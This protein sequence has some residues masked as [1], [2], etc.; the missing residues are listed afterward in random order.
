MSLP[1]RPSPKDEA[2]L[3]RKDQGGRA[4]T[5][6]SF[7]TQVLKQDIIKRKDLSNVGAGAL[8]KLSVS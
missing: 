2:C 1:A 6:L 7:P 3:L 8:S 5:P 4:G